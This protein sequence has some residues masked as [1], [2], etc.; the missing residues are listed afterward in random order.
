M[1]TQI[2]PQAGKPMSE[3][4]E[5]RILYDG[6]AIYIGVTCHDR[7]P[8]GI[9]ARGRERDGSVLSG[10]HVALFF[11]TFHDSRNGYVFAVS[12]DEGRWDAAVS[13][14]SNANSDW[15]GIWEAKCVTGKAGWT[16][17]IAIPFKSIAFSPEASVWGFNF[18]RTIA[19]RG[20]RGRRR[21][22][23][24][25]ETRGRSSGCATCR[26]TSG[27]KLHPTSWGV[28]AR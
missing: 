2:E 20:E 17:E 13:N 26:K 15:D 16:A 8:A 4:T 5:V 14:H 25:R 11:D 12:P 9:M 10:D 19:R 22:C 28:P 7:D 6:E 24:S 1:L 23:I 18:S 21:R 3:P 27:W